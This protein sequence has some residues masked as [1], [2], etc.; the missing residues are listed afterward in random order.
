MCQR[1]PKSR[2]CKIPWR[3]YATLWDLVQPESWTLCQGG[4]HLV[5][6]A[7]I[8][9]PGL[10]CVWTFASEI[11]N[12]ANWKSNW[13]KQRDSRSTAA[14]RCLSL[15]L[16]WC[17]MTVVIFEEHPW[18]VERRWTKLKSLQRSPELWQSFPVSTPRLSADRSCVLEK[19]SNSVP[20]LHSVWQEVKLG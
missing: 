3:L 5:L 15:I 18:R 13:S 16:H 11:P 20:C 12:L 19:V 17:S 6:L 1:D 10:C 7:E 4:W 9:L 8:I 14:T 2:Q